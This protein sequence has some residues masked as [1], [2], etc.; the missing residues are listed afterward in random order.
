MLTARTRLFLRLAASLTLILL[1]VFKVH[2]P[3]IFAVWGRLNV[4]WLL[5]ASLLAPVMIVSLSMRWQVFLRQQ[6]IVLPNRAVIRL[7][8]AGQFFNSVLP[9]STGGDVVKIYQACKM[10][11]EKK[12]GAAASVI[13]DRF[14]ALIALVVLAGVSLCFGKALPDLSL[15]S[16]PGSPAIWLAGGLIGAALAVFVFAKV[17]R[18]PHWVSRLRQIATTL[19]TSFTPNRAFFIGLSTAF[20]VHLTNVATFY[21]FAH[22]VGIQITYFQALSFFPIVLFLL[23]IPVTIN[24]HGLREM[25]LL[26]YFSHLHIA[27]PAASGGGPM[28]SV[29]SLSLLGVANDL[30]WALPGGLWYMLT[31]A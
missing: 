27:L 6:Q 22:A 14:T 23:M 12:A 21:A 1:L 11:P 28:E 20:L 2:W 16:L 19:R 26:F 18:S 31:L 7:T 25:L 17:I 5:G 13:V 4:P 24:G 9:G 30:L 3:V 10:A 29:L 8:W 15:K